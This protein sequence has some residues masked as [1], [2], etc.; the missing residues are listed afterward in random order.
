MSTRSWKQRV[1]AIDAAVIHGMERYGHFVERIALA[2]LFIW[3]GT[4]KV[5]GV[6]SAT[7]IIAKTV[8][9]GPPE[10]TVPVLGAW[11]VAIGVCFLVRRLNRIAILLLAI[12]LP[13]TLL[14][15]VLRPDECFQGSVFLPTIQGQ[16]LLKDMAIIGA[17]LVIGA[18]VRR[19]R[20]KHW[21]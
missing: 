20:G 19:D 7:S 2:I 15:L 4:L 8:Y 16:Y 11:E 14:A 3:F 17:A 9:V 6:E 21:L 18:M 1:D 13:G 10:I 5:I 12:R